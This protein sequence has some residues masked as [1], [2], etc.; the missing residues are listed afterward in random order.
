M[1][2]E[3]FTGPA[4]YDHELALLEKMKQVLESDPQAELFYIVPNHI[5]FESEINVLQRLA[6]LMH[7]VSGAV[8]VP[9]VQVFSLSRLAW[10]YMSEDP[11]Y[12]TAN[13]SKDALLMLVQRLLRKN[14][15]DLQLYKSM[16]N[17]PGF[18]SKFTDQLMELRQA[19]L[20]KTDL[21]AIQGD[22]K[23]AQTLLY[24]LHDLT[25]IGDQ[26]DAV[27]AERGQYLSSDLLLALKV[28][29]NTD[30]VNLQHHQFFINRYSQMTQGERGVTEALIANA[31]AVT[32]GLP[33]DNLTLRADTPDLYRPAKKL[34][35]SLIDYAQNL[36]IPT[37][38]TPLTQR[39]QLSETMV[40][41]ED[42]WA[43]YERTGV[44]TKQGAATI[45][46]DELQVWQANSLYQEVEQMARQIRQEVAAGE[47]R[48]RD[49]L[50]LARDLGPYQN[51]V[52][53]V[54]NRF[55]VPFFM[56]ADLSMSEH[57]FV[58]FLDTLL[59]LSKG[60]NLQSVMTLL[61]TELLRPVDI[62]LAIYRDALALTENFALAK[63]M[64]GWRFEA[65]TPWQYDRQ[66]LDMDDETVRERVEAKDQQIELIHQQISQVVSPFLKQIAQVTNA[67]DLATALYQFLIAQG[68]DQQLLAW[69]DEAVAQ[70][71][72]N[73]AQQPEQVWRTF[74]GVLD[75][76]VT[77][78]DTEAMTLA[79]LQDALQAGFNNAS[80]SGIPATMDQVRV[81]ESGIVQNANYD[82]TI[83]FGAT[84][85]NLPSNIR[86]QAILNDQ[87]R[88]ILQPLLPAGTE[89]RGTAEQEM[90][91]EPYL[92][93]SAMMSAT[94]RLIWL[95]ASSD[96]DKPQQASTYINRLQ[97]RFSVETQTFLALPEPSL[98]QLTQFVGTP[99]S[100]LAHLVM[101]KRLAKLQ[102]TAVQANW[103]RL[104]SQIYKFMPT[105]TTKL[106]GSLEYVSQATPIRSDLVTAL[107]GQDLKA[108]VS[109]LQS[110]ARNP[111]EF[112]L[113]YGL[114]LREREVMDLTPAEKGTYLHALF[115]GVFNQLIAEN[116]VLGQMQDAELQQR[117]QAY[118]EQL[119]ASGDITFDIFNSSA[120]MRY[121]TAQ[122]NQQVIYDLMQMRRGQ[123]DNQRVQ[124]KR[125]EV[126]FGL[127]K[128]G[129]PPV[130]Y[131]LDQGSVTVRGKIDRFD[132][133]T[134]DGGQY[135][136][137]VDY[138]SSARK[139]DYKKVLSGLEL[140]L[141][142]YWAALAEAESLPIGG[143]TFF[144]AQ[145]PLVRGD[146]LP[147]VSTFTELQQ[148]ADTENAQ[149]GSYTGVLRDVPDLLT[150]L[151]TPE[152]M[153]K[154]FGF[155][156]KK[157]GVSLKAG[158]ET[159]AD[160]EI[161]TL[162][163]Y[164][165][166]MIENIANHILQGEFPLLPY[167]DK[168][169]SGLQY[170]DYAPVMLFDAMLGNTYRDISQYPTKRDAVL[171]QMHLDLNDTPEEEEN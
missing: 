51:I 39:R 59:S 137:V 152:G 21:E 158:H 160:D 104:E 126:G 142:T 170:S 49:Y 162:V 46:A 171:R 66:T 92:M 52:P 27:L 45:S 65:T 58:A 138:K 77:V 146:K 69:R 87:D 129:L 132:Q 127:G 131:Q 94:R 143:A 10:Y 60:I 134:T 81:S 85:A 106:M 86:T 135:L 43:E 148:A 74:I 114:R 25:L 149:G 16:L 7:H 70:G 8:S 164:N 95:Y 97:S 115:E 140:Q 17:K 111:Y 26:L 169:T 62:D 29:L 56:D 9:R 147:L 63:N 79:E 144:D 120:R 78:F 38:V 61:K 50:L 37:Q 18:V 36:D 145:T 108:S 154:L 153:D 83:V 35:L 167:R 30:K 136:M 5:K 96:G 156:F 100:S 71:D 151:D 103:Q 102:H 150:A 122:L 123:P 76:F 82:T 159:Y 19:G 90:N 47:H 54:F 107:F 53:A 75:D 1:A 48:Y 139:F 67:R 31:Q 55:E 15:A 109:R 12:H 64:P 32:L 119:L 42:F 157:D 33:T 13:V 130:K 161:D 23:N 168:Q 34:G 91:Q 166:W 89:I 141:M 117:V 93:Y 101:V 41:V 110:Y 3:I 121:L 116:K 11:I 80:Y 2:L 57:P 105:M 113:Q 165:E 84:S 4:S 44:Q 133:V 112:F 155:T 88:D 98:G 72:L 125:T 68:V 124:T 20:Q 40:A 28:Y 99:A 118:A 73:L 22:V 6:E 24:K 128:N 14:Q 163:R